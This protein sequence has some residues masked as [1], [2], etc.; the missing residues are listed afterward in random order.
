M[1]TITLVDIKNEIVTSYLNNGKWLH[2][3]TWHCAMGLIFCTISFLFVYFDPGA[4]GSGVPEVK[5]YL[6]GVQLDNVVR[7]RT[8]FAKTGSV[9]FGVAS[10]LF[11]GPEGP[12]V[13]VGAIIGASISRL[14]TDVILSG[15]YNWTFTALKNNSS[16]RDFVTY[17]A[18]AG[19]AAAF[20]APIGGVLYILE[21]GASFWSTQ[22]TWRAFFCSSVTLLTLIIVDRA[23]NIEGED[24]TS[25]FSFGKFSESILNQYPYFLIELAL[26]FLMGCVGGVLGALF[27][28][29]NSL[30]ARWRLK[31]NFMNDNKKRFVEILFITLLTAWMTFTVP[32]IWNVC[33]DRP[34]D[35]EISSYTSDEKTLINRLVQ[36]DCP[37][38]Q[39]NQV[40]S[41]FYVDSNTAIKLL[42]HFREHMAETTFDTGSLIVVFIPY[43]ILACA[44]CGVMAAV[45]AFVSCLVAGAVLGRLVGHVLK[46]YFA[47]V[48]DAGTYALVGAAAMIGGVCRNTISL[49]VM[50]VESTGN[51][52]YVLP[53]ML[54]LLAAKHI[55]DILSTGLYDSLVIDCDLPMLPENMMQMGMVNLYP[56][57]EFMSK[58][59]VYLQEIERV[60]DVVETLQSTTHNLFPIIN[61]KGEIKG[62][63]KRK[64]LLG[65][66]QSSIFLVPL[67]SSENNIIS[68]CPT[69]ISPHQSMQQDY[70]TLTIESLK[71]PDDYLS[72]WIDL[73]PYLDPAPYIILETASIEKTFKMFRTLGLRHLIVIDKK[74]KV[75]G[76]ITRKDLIPLELRLHKFRKSDIQRYFPLIDNLTPVTIPMDQHIELSS[77]VNSY[78]SSPPSEEYGISIASEEGNNEYTDE[79][80]LLSSHHKLHNQKD[81]LPTY[82]SFLLSSSSSPSSSPSPSNHIDESKRNHGK[83]HI[84]SKLFF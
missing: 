40:A 59:V 13:H 60:G 62:A 52:H 45:G 20:R 53:I 73:R 11:A 22:L 54:S 14:Y 58:P 51:L 41:L 83:I 3:F 61:D 24:M 70:Q 82:S 77:P 1:A 29:F 56:V 32:L 55:G 81:E 49:T 17:G 47:E 74:C 9:I 65:M 19:I 15:T 42:F 63:I 37:A 68:L 78:H 2:A 38:K 30:L 79:M 7:L 21:E 31:Y 84:F 44:T 71:I 16:S 28:H 66:L 6:N 35:A 50:L 12:M 18:A 67:E 75:S 26:F 72:Y 23:L 64:T 25:N 10:G 8:L 39:Y 80:G 5:S 36:F 34:T 57:S 43:F 33:S 27:V 4:L 76:I 69:H 46:H 48:S